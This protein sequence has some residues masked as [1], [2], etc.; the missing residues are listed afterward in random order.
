MVVLTD[1]NATN[2]NVI[3]NAK[4]HS[5]DNAHSIAIS[6]PQDAGARRGQPG[7]R[8]QDAGARRILLLLL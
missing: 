4:N 1:S 3:T 6:R 2:S 7:T 5:N 8:P